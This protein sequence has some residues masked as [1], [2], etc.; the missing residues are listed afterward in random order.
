MTV[1]ECFPSHGEGLQQAA[2]AAEATETLQKGPQQAVAAW[3]WKPGDEHSFQ[4]SVEALKQMVL[5]KIITAETKCLPIIKAGVAMAPPRYETELTHNVGDVL[6]QPKRKDA[7]RKQLAAARKSDGTAAARPTTGKRSAPQEG[8]PLPKKGRTLGKP[9]VTFVR[10][11]MATNGVKPR[12]PGGPQAKN[13]DGADYTHTCHNASCSIGA[14]QQCLPIEWLWMT[15]FFLMQNDTDGNMRHYQSLS[16]YSSPEKEGAL[17]MMEL[18]ERLV[19]KVQSWCADGENEACFCDKGKYGEALKEVQTFFGTT[20]EEKKEA[21]LEIAPDDH[22]II[23]CGD[24]DVFEHTPNAHEDLGNTQELYNT[25][26][27]LTEQK[28]LETWTSED[29]LLSLRLVTLVLFSCKLEDILEKHNKNFCAAEKT[30][31][32]DRHERK[33]AAWESAE[34]TARSKNAPRMD[35]RRGCSNAKIFAM[36]GGSTGAQLKEGC[37][38]LRICCRICDDKEDAV[39]AFLYTRLPVQEEAPEAAAAEEAPEASAS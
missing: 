25:L 10:L 15:T 21:K 37:R 1:G 11:P 26:Y 17:T 20:L 12:L 9:K 2:E 13:K 27:D 7:R 31:A 35:S 3:L 32:N 36:C 18:V 39:Q 19:E 23:D 14:L 22:G 28:S 16:E 38:V 8:E 33:L 34:A 30:K 29:A 4:L 6:C 24:I 5:D